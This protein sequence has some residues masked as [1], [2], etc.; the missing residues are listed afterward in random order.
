MARAVDDIDIGDLKS[1]A[2][3]QR[4]QEAMQPV[5]I[6][7]RQ[8]QFARKCLQPAAGVAGTVAQD[9]ITYRVGDPRLHLL[10]TGI[11]AADPLA[12][13]KSDAAAAAFDRRNQSWQERRIVLPVAVERRDDGAV[14]G[15]NAAANR[16]RL[17]RRDGMPEL[18]EMAVL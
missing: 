6:G 8:E 2:S 18:P 12:G 4:R 10:E 14:R 1:L 16:R 11:L 9:R 17:P 7:H 3:H 15:A 13:H 5:E